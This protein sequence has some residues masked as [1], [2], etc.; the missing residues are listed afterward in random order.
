MSNGASLLEPPFATVSW[1]A[2]GR[3]LRLLDQR[4][5]PGVELYLETRDVRETVDAIRT[6]AVRGAPAIGVAAAIGLVVALEHAIEAHTGLND[7]SGVDFTAPLPIARSALERLSQQLDASRPTAVNLRWA[8]QRMLRVA[9]ALPDDALLRGLRAEA[10]CILEEDRAMCLAIGEAGASFITEGSGV[11]TH[12]NAGALATAGI[13]T[14]LAPMYVAHARGVTFHVF[15][16]ETRPLLQG[17]RLTSWELQRAGIQVTVQPDGAAASL[18]RSGAVQAVFVG[19]DRIAANGDVANKVGTYSLALAARVH[20]VPFHV[21]APYS[22]FDANTAT[23]DDIE[24]EHR[25]RDE[26]AL[27]GERMVLPAHVPV[28]NPAFDVTPR[29]LITHYITERGVLSP[30]FHI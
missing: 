2:D 3:A 22:T 28:N 14:A 29:E 4:R 5:L 6:L 16:D 21:C 13:G 30:P 25:H 26:I 15:A 27:A 1:S 19:A 11:L 9:A 24:I 10:T 18:L 7:L 12:C 23:G 20:G 17:A 8:L